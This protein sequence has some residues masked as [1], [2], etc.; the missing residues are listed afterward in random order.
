MQLRNALLLPLAR[1]EYVAIPEAFISAI[2]WRTFS[3][4][5]DNEN[6]TGFIFKN[7]KGKTVKQPKNYTRVSTAPQTMAD[8]DTFGSALQR[9]GVTS[10]ESPE[11]MAEAVLNSISGIQAERGQQQPATPLSPAIAL[12]QN[13]RGLASKR[14]PPDLGQ[15]LET[16]YQLGGGGK[17][18]AS[19]TA[20]WLRAAEQRLQSDRL[21]NA[22][23]RAVDNT[24]LPSP[25][26]LDTSH[27]KLGPFLAA[28]LPTTPYSWLTRSWD[29]L[30]S[31]EWVE[32]LPARVWVDWATTVLRLGYGMGFLWEAAWYEMMAKK[33]LS[34]EQPPAGENA[35]F[36]DWLASSVGEVLPWKSSR[37]LT[38]VRDVASLK[39]R[40]QKAGKIR[41]LLDK[42][43][44]NA[45]SSESLAV[46]WA[47]LSSDKELHNELTIAL[48]SKEPAATNLV[49]EAIRYALMT[50]EV[51]GDS[52]DYYGLLSSNGRY[53]TVD[54][55]TEWIA[56]VASLACGSPGTTSNV[57]EVMTS[58]MELG[59]QPELTELVRLLERAG[60]ARG[61]ADADQAVIVESAFS[62]GTK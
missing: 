22:I 6:E 46:Q 28:P 42:K 1:P 61:S 58:L 12:L 13:T 47:D 50:R 21:L 49:W 23:D 32:A 27:C 41:K 56:V 57:S 62:R 54:P 2:A 60:L 5:M 52:A 20:R 45:S 18:E 51:A 3:V 8:L 30:T 35:Q 29:T 53:L 37:S 24:L 11:M 48:G 40:V 44:G 7:I 59:T 17:G 4:E 26:F 15:I 43:L 9:E 34:D 38:S 33:L 39:W 14:N 25:R 16:L 36:V 10:M 31:D 55:G 19:L